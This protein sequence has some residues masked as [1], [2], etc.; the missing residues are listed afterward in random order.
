MTRMPPSSALAIGAD[1]AP[2]GLPVEPAS[3]R[4]YLQLLTRGA[5]QA[6][7]AELAA[8]PRSASVRLRAAA[9]LRPTPDHLRELTPRWVA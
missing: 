2:A 4:P 5:E 1:G 3:H 9:R 8:N 6:D 7:D